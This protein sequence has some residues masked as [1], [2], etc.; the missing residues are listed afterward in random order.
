[1]K[2][3][4]LFRV[5]AFLALLFACGVSIS[6]AFGNDH[7]RRQTVYATPVETVWAVP[8]AY[9][10]PTSYYLPTTTAYV[11]P[12][13]YSSSYVLP[14]YFAATSYTLPSASYYTPTSLA[15]YW[16]TSYYEPTVAYYA[17]T[18]LDYPI[19]ATMTSTG[20]PEGTQVARAL[21]SAPAPAPAVRDKAPKA[22]DSQPANPP[23][24][25]P[26][27]GASVSSRVDQNPSDE[28]VK[29]QTPPADSAVKTPERLDSLEEKPSTDVKTPLS[30]PPADEPKDK[31]VS[32][33]S[34]PA[35]EREPAKKAAEALPPVPAPGPADVPLNLPSPDD[36]TLQREARRPVFGTPPKAATNV[37]KGVVKSGSTGELVEGARITVANR[38]G[39]SPDR[40]FESDAY[41]RF[42]VRLQ[43]G[44][45]DV[46][47]TMPSGRVWSVSQL[48]I[49]NGKIVDQYGRDIPSLVIT[50]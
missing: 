4:R 8:T 9:V 29:V 42:A 30:A 23:A 37:L 16:P 44:S 25:A 13:V 6:A 47:V 28:S 34:P 50:R 21:P 40:T 2:I 7:F 20:C 33:P 48:T 41:G 17:P 31:P 38:L 22:V 11:V 19:V 18:V 26:P 5:L 43:D 3:T 10:Y 1:M 49:S 35:A 45:W 14:R 12:T 36:M 32:P 39:L 24:A 15:Y 46:R 27:D